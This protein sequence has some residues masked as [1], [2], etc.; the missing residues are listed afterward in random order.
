M[1]ID[2][3]LKN[4]TKTEKRQAKK[5]EVDIE[6]EFV[7]YAKTKKCSALK[8]ILLNL[9]GWPDRTILCP[10]ARV[11]FIEFK[12]TANEKQTT[13]QAKY[14][15]HIERFGFNYHVCHDLD[16]AKSILDEFLK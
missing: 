6:K 9:R 15:R 3:F 8:L 7:K 13:G 4:A 10:G 12:R 14:Q 1:G 16:T 11:L 5:L 2:E